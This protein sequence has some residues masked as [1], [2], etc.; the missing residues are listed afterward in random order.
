MRNLKKNDT[1]ELIYKTEI[2]TDIENKLPVLTSIHLYMYT[3]ESLGPTP[4]TKLENLRLIPKEI[5]KVLITVG[6]WRRDT[7]GI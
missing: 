5:V 7:C 4:E 1:N 2:V 3:T 6:S